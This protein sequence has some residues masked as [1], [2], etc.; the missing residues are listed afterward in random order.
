MKPPGIDLAVLLI[1]FRRP[2]QFRQVFAQVRAARPSR[3]YLYQDGPR[4]GRPGDVEGIEECRR[5]AGGIDWECDVHTLYQTE[6]LGCDPSEYIAQK[7]MFETEDM[8]VILEDDDVPSQSFFPFCK[9]LLDEYANDT[10]IDRICGMNNTGISE[11]AEA[12]YLFARKG[13]I[14]G[15]ASWRRVL[16]TWDP[17]YSWLDDE[18]A[19]DCLR[20]A[21]CDVREYREFLR[22]AREHRATG[23][24]HYESVGGYACCA[25]RRL[26]IVP[27]Y[28]L[29]TS[30]GA[31]EESTHSAEMR[32]LPRRARA[33]FLMKRYEI[34]FPLT[35]P[36]DV[37]RDAVFERQ[38]TPTRAQVYLDNLER[39]YLAL[40]H[41]QFAR[42][43][44]RIRALLS[45]RQHGT[46]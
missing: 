41:R 44:K 37:K 38:M 34:D 28:N 27:K 29:I 46:S 30:V 13:S 22:V 21:F 8:G 45:K 36:G 24:P 43:A 4:P 1:F 32:M 15:W 20:D 14:W 18:S 26:L 6:N 31:N 16:D 2:E 10:R 40:R 23:V 11:H 17:A 33:L 5:I 19:V 39:L 35:H 25:A 9:T 3:L 12:S 7:W 42:V